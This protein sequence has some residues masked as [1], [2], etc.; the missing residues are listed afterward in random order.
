MVVDKTKWSW[1]K[2]NEG[3]II[4][5]WCSQ[6][7]KVNDPN[8]IY[9]FIYFEKY[10]IYW[11]LDNIKIIYFTYNISSLLVFILTFYLFINCLKDISFIQ[12]MWI[13]IDNFKSQD[14]KNSHVL[15]KEPH[16]PYLNLQDLLIK[17]EGFY[18]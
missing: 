4:K 6:S 15:L 11:K 14:F 10:L 16:H 1:R 2:G 9:L 5:S 3:F 12:I 13:G 7:K 17:S 18:S 8:R